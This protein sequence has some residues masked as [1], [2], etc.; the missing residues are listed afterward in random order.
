MGADKAGRI[1]FCGFLNGILGSC[2]LDRVV[3]KDRDEILARLSLWRA[4]TAPSSPDPSQ[5]P[6]RSTADS[7]PGTGLEPEKDEPWE[8]AKATLPFWTHSKLVAFNSAHLGGG[9]WWE[10]PMEDLRLSAQVV[11]NAYCENERQEKMMHCLGQ[12][13]LDQGTQL[14]QLQQQH[15][16]GHLMPRR[17]L[18]VEGEAS[19]DTKLPITAE[20][21]A[22][23]QID[24]PMPLPAPSPTPA[25]APAL[26]P[27]VTK[28]PTPQAKPTSTKPEAP[29]T[30]TLAVPPAAPIPGLTRAPSFSLLTRTRSVV[31]SPAVIF[32]YT[33]ADLD[34]LKRI[35]A[36]L[37]DHGIPTVD[38]TQVALYETMIPT[39]DG[40][41]VL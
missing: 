5:S 21:M 20:N 25:P 32:S 17:M 9:A 30:P 18:D 22:H 41:H 11:V 27:A 19:I 26:A 40:T 14:Q 16:R 12:H 31:D 15:Q 38:G 3:A 10:Q 2:W 33:T 37:N 34:F 23:Q 1:S 35:R 7:P 36:W 24:A 8:V 6:D 4:M 29:C 28:K 13:Q 39:V